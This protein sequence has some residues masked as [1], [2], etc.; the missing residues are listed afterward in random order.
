MPISRRAKL[1]TLDEKMITIRFLLSLI[2]LLALAGCSDTVESRY[3]N[4]TEAE[5]D[6]LFQRGWLPDIIPKSSRDIVTK[7]DLDINTSSGEFFFSPDDSAE[8]VR[9]LNGIR[10]PRREYSSFS[11]SNKE[12]TWF[13]EVN[14]NKGHCK[15]SSTHKRATTSEQGADGNPH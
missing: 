2:A 13:F 15:Y 14:F 4:R 6:L 1:K 11:Y 5:A 7:N 3:S 8:F 10:E 12:S 9:H